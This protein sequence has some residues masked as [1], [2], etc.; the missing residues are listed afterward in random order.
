MVGCARYAAGGFEE[1][2]D[3]NICVCELRNSGCN[4]MM[5]CVSDV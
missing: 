1:G 2:M 5:Y 4:A 3:M